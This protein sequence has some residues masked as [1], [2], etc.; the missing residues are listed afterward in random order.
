MNEYALITKNH[1]TYQMSKNSRNIPCGLLQYHIDRNFIINLD[2]ETYRDLNIEYN[3]NFILEQHS[4][5]NLHRLIP[6]TKTGRQ[7]FNLYKIIVIIKCSSIDGAICI[8]G[9]LLNTNTNQI[10]LIT[11]MNNIKSNNYNYRKINSFDEN[12][13]ICKCKMIAPLLFWDE[14][15]NRLCYSF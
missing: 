9:A 12:W 11:S 4:L 3:N 6:N 13:K 14:L 5:S 15:K 7:N 2:I 1:I 8:K 10:T